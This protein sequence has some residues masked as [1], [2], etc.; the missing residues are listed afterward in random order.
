MYKRHH[1]AWNKSS[2]ARSMIISGDMKEIFSMPL[3][4]L[5]ISLIF[6]S[7]YILYSCCEITSSSTRLFIPYTLMTHSSSSTP[8]LL[9]DLMSSSPETVLQ[10]VYIL[11]N[12]CSHQFLVIILENTMISLW[13]E[14]NYPSLLILSSRPRYLL[15]IRM[16]HFLKAALHSPGLSAHYWHVLLWHTRSDPGTAAYIFSFHSPKVL[17]HCDQVCFLRIRF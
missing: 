11:G 3:Q 6:F 15:S 9:H 12:M 14:N 4:D 8:S 13:S 17:P 2:D 1:R 7:L 5:E 16:V 10:Q